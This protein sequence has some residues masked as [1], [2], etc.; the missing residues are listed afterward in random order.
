M[1]SKENEKR[2][3]EWMDARKD[4]YL[5]D[6]AKLVEI[7]SV[8]SPGITPGEFPFG[9]ESANV[10]KV[11]KAL[12]ESY[13][14][15]AE[16]RDNFCVV[17]NVGSGEEK[18]GLFGHLDVVPC[19]NDWNY[20]PFKLTVEGDY[21]RGRG[22][23]DDKGPLLSAVYSVRCLKE[24]GILPKREIEIFMGGD[25][26]C[27]MEDIEHYKATSE[28]LPVVSLTPDGDYPICY[29]EKGTLRF[30]FNI[31]NE[32]SNLLNFVGGTVKNVVAGHAEALFKVDDIAT[33]VKAFDGMENIEATEEN[34]VLKVIATGAS[35]HASNPDNGINAIG[36][37]ANAVLKAGIANYGAQKALEFVSLVNK[38]C[39]GESL[40]AA[41]EDEPSGKLTHV[42]GVM[43]TL[44]NGKLYMSMDIRYPVTCDGD[45][46]FEKIKEAMKDYDVEI[47]DVGGSKPIYNPAES[48]FVKMCMESIDG[49]F[50]R[51]GWKP[52]TMGG[53]TYAR[54]LK[55]AYALGPE[56]PDNRSPFGIYRGSIHQADESASIKLLMDTAKLYARLLINTDDFEF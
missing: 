56:D 9:K 16:N 27:G 51:E 48:G 26:E 25:E 1:V 35:V 30:Y 2:I 11:G 21:I 55:N 8:A 43:K 7:P 38:D 14:F 34:G 20:P 22:V 23:L 28:K 40:G 31:N 36:L 19:E 29:G 50:H 44:E 39:H 4:E 6:L 37:L 46:I 47:T 42:G 5:N 18:I 52:Y 17:A 41:F 24:L 12:V 54:K 3:D 13:G 33:A 53:G 15:K 10:L 32:N 49:V 45:T